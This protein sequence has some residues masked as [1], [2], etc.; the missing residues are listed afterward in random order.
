MK[1]RDII[2]YLEMKIID[3]TIREDEYSLYLKYKIGGNEAFLKNEDVVR[4]L[5]REYIE[6]YEGES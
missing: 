2:E 1:I 6:T 5:K 3:H 4:E